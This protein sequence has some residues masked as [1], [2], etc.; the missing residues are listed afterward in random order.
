MRTDFIPSLASP[1]S[2]SRRDTWNGMTRRSISIKGT[3][4][5]EAQFHPEPKLLRGW[6][7]RQP[8]ERAENEEFEPAAGSQKLSA[9][10]HREHHE[11][12]RDVPPTLRICS[13]GGRR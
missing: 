6:S 2:R 8:T 5:A 10:Q 3:S 12:R 4:G 13:A 9:K 11:K 1:R 7:C